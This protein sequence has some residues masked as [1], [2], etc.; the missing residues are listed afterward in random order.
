MA[1]PGLSA[2]TTAGGSNN[3]A[4]QALFDSANKKINSGDN[5]A[6][7]RDLTQAIAIDP[8]YWKAYANRASAR[9]NN[10]DYNGAIADIDVALKH[11][12]NMPFLV[13]LRQKCHNAMTQSTSNAGNAQIANRQRA[14]ALLQQAMLGGDLSDPST[15]L[16][17]QAQRRGLLNGGGGGVHRPV[18]N[19]F[20][21]HP[22]TSGQP[23]NLT[24]G[25]PA[26]LAPGVPSGNTD[27]TDSKDVSAR[28]AAMTQGMPAKVESATPKASGSNASVNQEG[29]GTTSLAAGNKLTANEHFDRGCT[30]S[31]N[32]DF[33]G[34][35]E[36]FSQS[37]ALGNKSGEVFANRGLARIHTGD[38]KG[39]L[40]DLQ[41]ADR[42]MPNNQELKR[43][44]EVARQGANR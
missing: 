26:N 37:I 38:F 20:A 19:P 24:P 30:K 6:A 33:P 2:E 42:L 29:A 34:A 3:K 27:S 7:V 5:A 10:H 22:L 14:N 35:I 39:A 15:I 31:K 18:V 21:A 40:Q 43:Y 1:F 4:A 23:V 17:M 16:M 28:L 13:D 12:P 41:E 25:Q 11:F 36:E 32:L 9:F 8:N 44:I